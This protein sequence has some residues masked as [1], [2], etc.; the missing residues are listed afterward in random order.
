MK[1]FL[2]MV[3]AVA[4]LTMPMT[5]AFA[6]DMDDDEYEVGRWNVFIKG[7]TVSG[8]KASFGV[9]TTKYSRELEPAN[10]FGAELMYGLS[11][12]GTGAF[13][14][15]GFNHTLSSAVKEEFKDTLKFGYTDL[16]FAFRGEFGLGNKVVS[17]FYIP[18]HIG[19]T[20][21][22]TDSKLENTNVYHEAWLY[23]AIGIGLTFFNTVFVEAL[24]AFDLGQIGLDIKN[25]WGGDDG[26]EVYKAMKFNVGFKFN[27]G[28]K[29][30]TRGRFEGKE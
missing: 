1:K 16:Y 2:V 21:I 25:K 6:K 23:E 8:A 20:I 12:K 14:G 3:L 17:S 18:I 11:E 29:T 7:G 24:Y 10:S 5:P 28:K 30:A 26:G 19:G 13:V 27:F 22:H 4:L 15:F 9:K